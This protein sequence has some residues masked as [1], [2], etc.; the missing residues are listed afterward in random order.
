VDSNPEQ[1]DSRV[2]ATKFVE[3]LTSHQRDLYVY[4]NT[5]LM[6]DNA[7]PDVL[8]NT[9]LDLWARLDDFDFTRPFLPWAY[10]FAYQSVLA[11]RKT[12]RRSRLVFSDEV[13]RL[14]SDT[15]LSDP[16]DADARLGALRDCVNKLSAQ[17]KQLLRDR[18]FAKMSVKTLAARLGG[19]ANQISARLY[20][21]RKA[22]AKCIE[23][24]MAR[25]GRFDPR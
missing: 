12:Q 18:Y 16:A 25:E 6:N 17:H 22:L 20:R 8:Q 14:I 1:F 2:R 11:Y 19:T 13:V 15:Y 5:L 23:S 10:G 9:N 21:I 7:A 3:L 4:I 24:I